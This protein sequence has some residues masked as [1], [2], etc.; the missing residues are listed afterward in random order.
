MKERKKTAKKIRLA[1]ITPAVLQPSSCPLS[2]CDCYTVHRFYDG[3]AVVNIGRSSSSRSSVFAAVIVAIFLFRHH[4]EEKETGKQYYLLNEKCPNN[5]PSREKD[6]PLG[7]RRV[8][9][10]RCQGCEK[11][12]RHPVSLS[13]EC[14]CEYL[15]YRI[16]SSTFLTCPIVIEIDRIRSP[17]DLHL[18][19]EHDRIA[20]LFF[21][22]T[23][24]NMGTTE[25]HL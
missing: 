13:R 14:V 7:R 4:S 15:V 2:D 25:Q 1:E 24:F 18:N 10:G 20:L 8:L 11:H 23:K 3:R 22:P 9:S 6:H 12:R 5:K 16:S 19:H 21:P 17:K